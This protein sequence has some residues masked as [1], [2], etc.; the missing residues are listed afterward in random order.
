[1][2]IELTAMNK[3]RVN[4]ILEK[5]RVVIEE[6]ERKERRNNF[7]HMKTTAVD[8]GKNDLRED[9]RITR[10]EQNGSF[11]VRWYGGPILKR[12]HFVLLS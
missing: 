2:E 1:M 3:K 4:K 11:L 10:A 5:L 8:K 6:R 12:N 7:N 9:F